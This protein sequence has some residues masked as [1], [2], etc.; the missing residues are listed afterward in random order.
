MSNEKPAP[1]LSAEIFTELKNRIIHWEYMPDHRLTELALSEEFG[2]SRSPI[3]E[4]LQMLEEKGLV[5]KVP[6][7]GYTVRQPDLREVYELYEYRLALETF[8]VERLAN[9]G[10]NEKIWQKL[11]NQWQTCL[12]QVRQVGEDTS[13]LDEEFH[14][15]LAIALGNSV[16]HDQIKE[17]NERIHFIRLNDITTVGRFET[18]CHQ[19]LLILDAINKRDVAAARANIK[20]NIEEGRSNVDRAIKEAL[21]KAFIK[22]N[23]TND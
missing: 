20:Q 22:S 11:F 23:S 10:M 19:H 12:K 9:E 1:N 16:I 4:V 13:A 6:R 2:V 15:Q 18:T 7:L 21:S 17:V 5:K 14:E 3:R 8:I